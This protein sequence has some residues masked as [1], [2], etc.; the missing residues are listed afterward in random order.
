M[1]NAKLQASVARLVAVFLAVMLALQGV[2]PSVSFATQRTVSVDNHTSTTNEATALTDVTIDDVDKPVAG[3]ALDQTATVVASDDV[4]WDI[5]V[6][7]VRDDLA[8]R[9]DV[10]TSGH[11]YLPVLAFFVPQGYALAEDV[12]TVTLSDALA[13]LFGTEEIIS[14]YDASSGITYILPASLKDLFARARSEESATVPSEATTTIAQPSENA[15]AV[16]QP[17]DDETDNEPVSNKTLVEI[18]CANTARDVLTDEDLQWLIELIIDYLEPQAVELLLNSFP[19]FRTAANNG[20]IGKE[21][22]LYIYYKKGDK[23]GKPEHEGA[24]EA[25]AYVS[26]DAVEIDGTLK[27]CYMLAVDVDDLVK[28]DEEDEPM[29]NEQT[30]RYMLIRDGENMDTFK[31]TIV[32]E[33]FHAIMDD[34]NRTGMAGAAKLEDMLTDSNEAFINPGASERFYALRYPSWF[35]EGTASAVENVY[36]FRYR[37]FQMLRSLPTDDGKW[38]VGPLN[39]V[40][41]NKLLINNYLN[42]YYSTGKYAYFDIGFSRGGLDKDGDVIDTNAS[43]Y[44]TGYLATLYLCDLSARQ[45]YNG[46]SSVKIVDDTITVDSQMLRTG[47]DSLLQ[48]MHEG[49]TLD[50]LINSVSRVNGS[51]E[52]LYAD[53]DAFQAKFIKGVR[54]GDTFEGDAESQVFVTSFLNYML[55]LERNLPNGQKPN[56]S[57]LFEFSKQFSSP[58]D[59]SKKYTSQYLQIIDSNQYVPSTVK[60]DTTNIGGGKSSLDNTT[61]VTATASDDASKDAP[62]PAAAKTQSMAT[63]QSGADNAKEENAREAVEPADG[64]DSATEPTDAAGAHDE[65]KDEQGT[66]EGAAQSAAT[67]AAEPTPQSAAAPAAAPEPAAAPTEPAVSPTKQ[68]AVP[69]APAQDIAAQAPQTANQPAA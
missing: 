54:N 17:S 67:P 36:Q 47:L 52:P 15:T 49:S 40:F 2:L 14:V 50:E 34:Y 51:D 21:I 28:L 30:H 27:F 63:N 25:L 59:V 69:I 29:V 65:A 38:G 64:A 22:G 5:P 66:R 20:E 4:T 35:V 16:A 13:G 7:W 33:L 10:T 57:I 58:L 53:T 44:I 9:N 55:H 37:I 32:H 3:S 26:R 8:M 62:L 60:N 41:T 6:I 18:Y 68:A 45:C 43:R 42:G 48:R 12:Y 19:A 31:N 23:D 61:S 24:S 1:F 11:T 46:Q 39:D 56:G